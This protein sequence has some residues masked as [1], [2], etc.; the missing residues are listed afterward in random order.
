MGLDDEQLRGTIVPLY[1]PEQ[2]RMYAELGM[3][4]Q[5]DRQVAK[6]VEACRDSVVRFGD[7][8]P[9]VEFLQTQLDKDGHRLTRNRKPGAGIDGVFGKMTDRAVR[10]FQRDEDL[11][12]DGVVGPATWNALLD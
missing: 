7:R 2:F 5:L 8:G 3:P 9:V 10:Q 1:R 12:I 6:F 4:K 11:S